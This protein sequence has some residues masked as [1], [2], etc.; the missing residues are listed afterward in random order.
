GNRRSRRFFCRRL[1]LIRVWF[2][3][4]FLR[5][6]RRIGL[7]KHSRRQGQIQSS[8]AHFFQDGAVL[9]IQAQFQGL[10]AIVI[11]RQQ[12]VVII[13]AAV[14]H[15]SAEVDRGVNQGEGF[16]TVLCLDV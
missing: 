6:Q 1:R 7:G 15:A 10:L 16:A 2:R 13:R 3:R 12:V 4:W 9:L 5:G 14:Q 11:E 8:I